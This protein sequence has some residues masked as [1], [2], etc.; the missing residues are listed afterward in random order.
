MKVSAGELHRSALELR[1]LGKLLAVD[2]G[3]AKLGT[4]AFHRH[5]FVVLF[6]EMHVAGVESS[7]DVEQ[8]AGLDADRTRP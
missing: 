5:P 7:D 2:A 3:E 8:L 4:A 6:F 1:D